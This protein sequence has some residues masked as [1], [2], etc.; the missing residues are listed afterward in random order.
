MRRAV[1]MPSVIAG[2][3][4]PPEMWLTAYIIVST[5]KPKARAMPKK[6]MPVLGNFDASTAAPQPPKTSQKV[7]MN[8][9]ATFFISVIIK[10]LSVSGRRVYLSGSPVHFRLEAKQA[11]HAVYILYLQTILAAVNIELR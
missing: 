2:L 4:W 5:L 11:Q 1:N 7:P 10:L 6:P 3:K 9:A 8:S